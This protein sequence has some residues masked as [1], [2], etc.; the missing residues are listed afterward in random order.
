MVA[1]NGDNPIVTFFEELDVHTGE[2]GAVDL[3]NEQFDFAFAVRDYLT[4]N[5]LDDPNIVKWEA[6]VKYSDDG[7]NAKTM[8]TIGLHKCS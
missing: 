7:E 1:Y 3:D 2:S 6:I 5:F 8:Q 4:G